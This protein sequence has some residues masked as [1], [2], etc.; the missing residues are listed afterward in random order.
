MPSFS[1]VVPVF[2]SRQYL[3]GLVAAL[4]R[5]TEP[6]GG[7]EVI[8]VD[9]RSD[10]GG[11]EYLASACEADPRMRVLPGP[12][13]GPAAARNVGVAAA[14]GVYIAFTDPD[15]LP[16][17]DWLVAAAAAL[18]QHGARA[19]EGAVLPEGAAPRPMMRPVRNEDGGRYMTANMIYARALLEEVGGFDERFRPP[20]FLEDSDIAFRVM[21]A[22]AEIPFEPSVR[23]RHRDVPAT[24]RSELASQARLQ[25]MA[26]VASK[27]PERYLRQ[28]RPKV[29]T[30]RPGDVA[31]LVAVPAAAAARR[32]GTGAR[33]LSLG[34][35]AVAVRRVVRAS[36]AAEAPGEERASWIAAALAGPAVRAFHLV[37]G[38]LRFGHWPG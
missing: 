8:F 16:E 22:G 9:N 32:L 34:W 25:W 37:S 20:P 38:W 2:N 6:S 24:P 4:A 12:G 10:D 35:L 7:F 13:I 36:G 17:P 33:V 29:Q 31:L 26:L 14:T 15:T 5:L 18:E 3:E 28:L 27:H 23:V 30:F 11:V 21:D 1:V 19:L